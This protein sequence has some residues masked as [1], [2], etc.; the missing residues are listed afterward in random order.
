MS[1]DVFTLGLT[2]IMVCTGENADSNLATNAVVGS[3]RLSVV[4]MSVLC[5][6]LSEIKLIRSYRSPKGNVGW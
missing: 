1:A 5:P 3:G 6:A 2:G 4:F